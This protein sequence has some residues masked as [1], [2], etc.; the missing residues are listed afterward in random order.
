M[1]R[2][3]SWLTSIPERFWFI[4]AVFIG[5]AM[6]LAQVLVALDRAEVRLPGTLE[7]F[8]FGTGVDGARAL[9]TAV[10]SFLGVAGTAF[11]IT[12]SVISTA[13]T[14]YGPR[15]VRNFMRDRNNQIVLGV[16]VATFVY[17]LLVLRTIR[18]NS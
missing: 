14:S 10:A 11:S 9:L 13:S 3:R 15:L 5:A 6:A 4:P 16:L 7:G 2:L 8:L 18:S 1:G 17:T 12:I